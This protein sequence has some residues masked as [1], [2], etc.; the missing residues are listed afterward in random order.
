MPAKAPVTPLAERAK[1]LVDGNQAR[2]AGRRINESNSA[3]L[4]LNRQLL[5][6]ESEGMT[7]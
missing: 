4:R 5:P 7:Q 2:E 1:L 3:A 6:L